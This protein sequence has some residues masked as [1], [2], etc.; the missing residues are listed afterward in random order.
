[1][2]HCSLAPVNASSQSSLSS[3]SH[4]GEWRVNDTHIFPLDALSFPPHLKVC[5]QGA[6][7]NLI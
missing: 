4:W 3:I 1:M 2:L 7:W 6:G 5:L